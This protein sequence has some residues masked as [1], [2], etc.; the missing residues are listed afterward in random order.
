MA[1]SRWIRFPVHFPDQDAVIWARLKD[2]N[3]QPFLCT[4]R[5]DLGIQ[6][7]SGGVVYFTDNTSTERRVPWQF[8]DAWRPA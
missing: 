6:P 7:E 8:L 4:W 5:N 2:W 3:R 1:V